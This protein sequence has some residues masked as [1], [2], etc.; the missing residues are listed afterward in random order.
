M[1]ATRYG[2][3]SLIMLCTFVYLGPIAG[4]AYA[5]VTP[6]EYAAFHKAK[7]ETH[8]AKALELAQPILQA[9]DKKYRSNPGFG[10]YKSKLRLAEHLTGQMIKHL[11]QATSNQMSAMMDDVFSPKPEK[12]EQQSEIAPA[13][14]FYDTSLKLFSKP[15]RIDSL[16]PEE[17]SFL[18]QFYDLRLRELVSRITRTGQ[19]IALAEPSFQATHDYALVLP[20]LHTSHERPVNVDVFPAWL[21]RAEHFQVFSD[22]CLLHFGFPY[23]AMVTAQRSAKLDKAPFSELDFYQTAAKKCGTEH[24]HTSVDCLKRAYGH[25][26]ESQVD[27]RVSLL[28]DIVQSWL[29]SRNYALAAGQARQLFEV[30]PNHS[31]SGKAMWL[32]YYALSRINKTKE[33]LASID[34]ALKDPRCSQYRIN[35]LYI[36]WFALRRTKGEETRVIAVEHELLTQCRDNPIV[37]PIMLSR[38]TDFL[39]RQEYPS[40][41]DVLAEL[42]EK[43]PNT[44]AAAQA[45]KMLPKLM[46]IR[47]L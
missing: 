45:N 18:A 28:F 15:V 37:A 9:L 35:L 32:Y 33:I 24:V 11:R 39:A 21:M 36:K 29:D 5:N 22:S 26:E 44:Q 31:K 17:K 6:D 1:L 47:N 4:L 7:N 13:K 8:D 27:L 25:V 38:A 34:P 30:Y 43:F 40:A 10:A 12:E 3:L 23:Q 19:A 46:N 16:S 42:V 20:L 41:L 2:V 14:S